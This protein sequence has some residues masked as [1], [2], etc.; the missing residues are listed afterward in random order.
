MR[1]CHHRQS[2]ENRSE[3]CKT[4]GERHFAPVDNAGL[5]SLTGHESI[6]VC[7]CSVEWDYNILQRKSKFFCFPL[8]YDII[9]KIF[10]NDCNKLD[11]RS[12]G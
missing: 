7:R 12:N 8:K 10:C 3:Q 1:D 9:C 2:Q 11:L 4:G 6:F 5:I